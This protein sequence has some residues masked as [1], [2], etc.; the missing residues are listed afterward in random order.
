MRDT[1]RDSD[2]NPGPRISVTAEGTNLTVIDVCKTCDDGS[3][4]LMVV[5]CTASNVHG[6]I[7]AQGYLNVLGTVEFNSI[8]MQRQR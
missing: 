6:S 1:M 4:D 3:S 7:Y 5:Q 8:F 2:D